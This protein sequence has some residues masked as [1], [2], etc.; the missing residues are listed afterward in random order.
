METRTKGDR[1]APHPDGRGG[2]FINLRSR[3]SPWTSRPA[4]VPDRPGSEGLS[5]DYTELRKLEVG[6]HR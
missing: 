6:P 5:P 4:P 3:V 2:V 1:E